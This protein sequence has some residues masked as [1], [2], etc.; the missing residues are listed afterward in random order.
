[1]R[2]EQEEGTR[3]WRLT[4]RGGVSGLEEAIGEEGGGESAIIVSQSSGLKEEGG[5]VGCF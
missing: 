2:T 4:E 3:L 1:M 5:E